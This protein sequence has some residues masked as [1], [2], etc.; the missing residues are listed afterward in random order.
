MK[1]RNLVLTNESSRHPFR[2]SLPAYVFKVEAEPFHDE[3]QQRLE[4]RQEIIGDIKIVAGICA[5]ALFMLWLRIPA[6]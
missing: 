1:R 2:A 3:E 5:F 6:F 4:K